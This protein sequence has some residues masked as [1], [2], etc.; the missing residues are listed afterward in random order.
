LHPLNLACVEEFAMANNS[1]F[2]ESDPRHHTSNIKD[3]LD[4]L[5]TQSRDDVDK[6]DEPRRRQLF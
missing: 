4:D 2:P 6:I 5:I 3:M 1:N